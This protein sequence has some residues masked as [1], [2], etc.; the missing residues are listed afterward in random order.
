MLSVIGV[1]F[2]M[3]LMTLR[4]EKYDSTEDK[5][6]IETTCDQIC[7][8]GF[9]WWYWVPRLEVR[10]KSRYKNISITWLCFQ[11]SFEGFLSEAV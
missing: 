10:L 8:F 1:G 3:K 4:A 7:R 11:V 5:E 6:L 9:C 2:K